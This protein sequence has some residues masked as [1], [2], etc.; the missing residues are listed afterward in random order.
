MLGERE[1]H[2][3]EG[4]ELAIALST[5]DHWREIAMDGPATGL[6]Q[7]RSPLST[8]LFFCLIL[9][10][11]TRPNDDPFAQ[12]VL[13][14]S[15]QAAKHVY[16]NYSAWLNGT[17]SNYTEQAPHPFLEPLAQTALP[18]L[19]PIDPQRSSYWTNMTGF[20]NG[21]AQLYNLSNSADLP[22]SWAP[23]AA[24]LVKDLNQTEV[25]KKLGTWNWTEISKTSFR[26]S[27]PENNTNPEV[28]PIHGHLDLE[29]S[30]DFLKFEF[31]G[32]HL[33]S[34]GSIVAMMNPNGYPVDI[35]S[36]PP[37]FPQQWQNASRY[38]VLE[39]LR[40]HLDS[41]QKQLDFGKSD[42]DNLSPD[43]AETSCQFVF[44][45]HL[46]PCAVPAAK[47][48]ELEGEMQ[49]P[50]GISTVSRPPVLF[51][52]I[53]I[54]PDCAILV[55]MKKVDGMR[56]D[57]FWRKVSTY[58]GLASLVYLSLLVL[59]VR[60]METTR[61]PAAI[62]PI[63]RWGF[64]FQALMDSFA[65]TS[66]AM[67]GILTKNKASVSMVA[68]GFLACILAL[69]FE[70]RYTSLIHRVQAPEDEAIANSRPER[71]APSP[72]P[73]AGTGSAPTSAPTSAPISA[74]P[75]TRRF[76]LLRRIGAG[77]AHPD[78]RVW[79]LFFLLFI[80][81]L[82]A[83]SSNALLM[84]VLAVFHSMWVPQIVRNITRGTRK[85]LQK[86]YVVGTTVLRALLVL[87]YFVCPENILLLET[88]PWAYGIILWLAIQVLFL[89]VQ[90]YLGAHFF[91]PKGWISIP[92]VYD[93]HPNL[94]SD[95]EAPEQNLGDCAICLEPIV[96]RQEGATFGNEKAGDGHLNPVGTGAS[97]LINAGMRRQY[98]FTPCSHIMHTACLEQW[99]RVKSI[100]PSC[101]TPLPPL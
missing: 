66:H 51:D 22:T 10:L 70:I 67:F 37:L 100:C 28:Q 62:S 8:I 40:K 89:V 65:F 59:L 96:A 83:T 73:E 20:W 72:V 61:T 54:S 18:P 31:S 49:H 34:T 24:G 32:L 63:S 14:E 39:E 81:V 4:P 21:Q 12:N 45:G 19:S 55:E 58:A 1:G 38:V 101:R 47:L 60:Q 7:N 36:L 86:R 97:L 90:E 93:Y 43:N 29:S 9:Y 88:N 48:R 15:I 35:R 6:P 3:I 2:V 85:A 27:E 98:A 26:L 71:T 74:P 87:Y 42:E 5:A 44:Y 99:M 25:I 79:L 33:P 13:L 92:E 75:S 77:L 95:P 64:I 57:R 46:Q 41:L 56:V 30:I 69:M 94:M 82:Q 17:Q 23:I 68:P 53:L 84:L 11:T 16:G 91:I 78:G 80:L 52:G 50:T 76:E